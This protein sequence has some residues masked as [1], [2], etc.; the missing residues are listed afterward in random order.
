MSDIAQHVARKIKELRIAAGYSQTDLAKKLEI[1]P[2]TVSRWESGIYKPR[3]DDLDRLS[4]LFGKPIW[5]FFPSDVQPAN[6]AQRALLSATGDLPEEDIE[7]L[8]RFVDFVRA[9]KTLPKK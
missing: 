6:D 5:S 8:R 4:R 1:T 9:G 7:E 3:I 2:N